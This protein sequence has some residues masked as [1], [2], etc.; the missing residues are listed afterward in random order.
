MRS[1]EDTVWSGLGEIPRTF[2][3]VGCCGWSRL[4][5]KLGGAYDLP[6]AFDGL[7]V[8]HRDSYFLPCLLTMSGLLMD[9]C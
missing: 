9:S 7:S 8:C 3:L 2:R 1:W 5:M 6:K 4:G